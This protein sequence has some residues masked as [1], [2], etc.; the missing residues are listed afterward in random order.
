MM[1]PEEEGTAEDAG[2]EVDD[3]DPDASSEGDEDADGDVGDEVDKEAEPGVE[4]GEAEEERVPTVMVE[5]E[6]VGRDVADP[7]G[8]VEMG[9][10]AEGRGVSNDPVMRSSLN[11]GE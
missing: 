6:V 11:H 9:S 4:M 1:K 10:V 5:S 3:A 2:A 8:R 7:E